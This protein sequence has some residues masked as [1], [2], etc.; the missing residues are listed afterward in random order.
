MLS[1]TDLE[2]YKLIFSGLVT[3]IELKSFYFVLPI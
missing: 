1:V 2:A 3:Y